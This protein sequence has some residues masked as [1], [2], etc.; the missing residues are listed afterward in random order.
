VFAAKLSHT[1]GRVIDKLLG[2]PFKQLV[3]CWPFTERTS[4]EISTRAAAGFQALEKQSDTTSERTKLNLELLK[5]IRSEIRTE[6][7]LINNRLGWCVT[8]QAFLISALVFSRDNA[9]FPFLFDFVL[10]LL[11]IVLCVAVVFPLGWA[12]LTMDYWRLIEGAFFRSPNALADVLYLDARHGGEKKRPEW[13]HPISVTIPV[14]IPMF[15][16]L[17]WLGAFGHNSGW[18][19]RDKPT[20]GESKSISTLTGNIELPLVITTLL[21]TNASNISASFSIFTP[22]TVAV[23]AVIGTVH[24]NATGGKR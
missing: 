21:T 1:F 7:D 24:T 4:E 23:N 18:W 11:G 13:Y 2:F 10:P 17:F 3:Q 5:C 8:S 16:I 9:W 14:L 19:G 22:H 15:F 12:R 6:H 20:A